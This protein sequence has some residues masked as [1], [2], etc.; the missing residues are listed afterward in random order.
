MGT[1]RFEDLED[2][3]RHGTGFVVACLACGHWKHFSLLTRPKDLRSNLP[4]EMAAKRFRVQRVRIEAYFALS[5]QGA[6]PMAG[7]SL[8]SGKR[9]PHQNDLFGPAAKQPYRRLSDPNRR[10]EVLVSAAR[11][12]STQEKRCAQYGGQVCLSPVDAT[13]PVRLKSTGVWRV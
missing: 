3:N 6:A 7:Q 13:S 11:P 10:G 5:G 9:K 4:Y 1:K 8:G 12:G 2:Y